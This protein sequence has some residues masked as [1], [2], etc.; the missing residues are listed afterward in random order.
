MFWICK[1]AYLLKFICNP[2]INAYRTFAVICGHVQSGK[3]LSHSTY[4]FPAKVKQVTLCL[5]ISAPILYT[6]VS[7]VPHFV[8]FCALRCWLHCLKGSPSRVL[9]VMHKTM[10]CFMKKMRMLDKLDSGKSCRATGHG[11]NVTEPTIYSKQG[12]SKRKH[13]KQG[14]ML[15]SGQ[16]RPLRLAGL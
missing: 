8:H 12:V 1:F 5:L 13:I 14:Y 16:K 10:M 4:M 2:K 7:L 3:K 15:I 11:F 6:S 9:S